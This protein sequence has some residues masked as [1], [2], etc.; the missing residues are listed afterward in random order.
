M[1]YFEQ[2]EIPNIVSDTF[3][4]KKRNMWHVYSLLVTESSVACCGK[5]YSTMGHVWQKIGNFI[6]VISFLKNEIVN[7]CCKK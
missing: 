7:L 2:S 3:C 6:I 1:I 5:L 4:L